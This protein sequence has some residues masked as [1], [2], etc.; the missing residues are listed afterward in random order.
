VE[1]YRAKLGVRAP[2]PREKELHLGVAAAQRS[3]V[4]GASVAG[5]D[6]LQAG[7][8][9]LL[10]ERIQAPR[11][12]A[13][14]PEHDRDDGETGVSLVVPMTSGPPLPPRDDRIACARGH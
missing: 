5:D 14:A 11:K 4:A 6:D 1:A 7:H 9:D 12:V 13:A 8:T 10:L 3:E 2:A